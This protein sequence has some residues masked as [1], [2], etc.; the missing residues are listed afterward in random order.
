VG[1][2]AGKGIL[3][4]LLDASVLEEVLIGISGDGK[5]VWNCHSL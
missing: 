3:D 5:A 2:E 4:G 1:V